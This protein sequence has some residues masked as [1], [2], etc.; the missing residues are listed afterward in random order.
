MAVANVM[1]SNLYNILLTL[2]L[3]V[4][5]APNILTVSPAALALDI[6]FMVAVSIMCIPIFIAGFDITKFD[7]AI[8]LFY[9]GSYLTYLVLDAVGSSFEQTMETIMLYGVIP[10]T[11]IY[12]FRRV[13]AHRKQLKKVISS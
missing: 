1:G 12:I 9:Y 6:P 5:I 8:L 11:L 13:V 3:T 7:G 10:A 2:G 4:V